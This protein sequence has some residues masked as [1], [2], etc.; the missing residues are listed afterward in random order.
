M[1]H[2]KVWKDT[3]NGNNL[4]NVTTTWDDNIHDMVI[5]CVDE[6]DARQL[7]EKMNRAYEA[8]WNRKGR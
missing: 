6:A 3:G 5:P 2:Y 4:W 8:E 1:N 7:C